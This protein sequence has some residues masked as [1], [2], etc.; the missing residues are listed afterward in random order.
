MFQTASRGRQLSHDEI[1]A[2][3]AAFQGRPFNAAWSQ[4]ARIVYDGMVAAIRKRQVSTDKQSSDQVFH[5][6]DEMKVPVGALACAGDE[7]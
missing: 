6:L 3:E 2:A 1:K 7:E 5:E 4:A